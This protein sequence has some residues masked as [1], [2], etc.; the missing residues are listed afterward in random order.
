M[1]SR[2]VTLP[3]F[4]ALLIV[5]CRGELYPSIYTG[6]MAVHG[7]IIGMAT[8]MHHLSMEA[9]HCQTKEGMSRA[10]R[11]RPLTTAV[12][13]HLHMASFGQDLDRSSVVLCPNWV[14]L[15]GAFVVPLHKSASK[16]AFQWISRW[17]YVCDLQNMLVPKLMESVSKNP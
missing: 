4:F 1:L 5:C 17:I 8:E 12:G 14:E 7:A 6:R 16:S 13:H 10:S 3:L 2:N 9:C 11:G 15:M